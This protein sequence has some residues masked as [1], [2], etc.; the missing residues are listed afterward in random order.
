L[1]FC[2]V[3]ITAWVGATVFVAATNDDPGDATPILR[4]FAVGGAVFL[5]L[6]FAADAHRLTANRCALRHSLCGALHNG[7]ATAKD[8]RRRNT[9]R[10]SVP[11]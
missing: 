3:G 5:A 6:L 2:V 4:T 9:Q 1:L 10:A 8:R 11:N 7:C